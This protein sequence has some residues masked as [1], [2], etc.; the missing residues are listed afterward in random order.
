MFAENARVGEDRRFFAV[1]N[2]QKAVTNELMRLV[3]V[4]DHRM[5]CFDNNGDSKDLDEAKKAYKRI[6][7]LCESQLVVIAAAR[8]QG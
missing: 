3:T 5:T 7:D 8:M 6:R 1:N 4:A 2:T